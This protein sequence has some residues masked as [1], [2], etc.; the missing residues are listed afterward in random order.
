MKRLV[1]FEEAFLVILSVFM[2]SRLH[3]P[4]WMF[5]VLFFAPD[6]SM[7]GYA[8]GSRVGAFVYNFFHHRAIAVVAY[9]LGALWGYESAQLAGVIMLGHSSFDRV[10]GYGLKY[11]DSF[12]HTHLGWI[13]KS[14]GGGSA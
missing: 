1:L 9:V 2:F 6:L 14:K 7:V 4:W 12:N 3:Y 8:A 5:L 11:P 10:F 13:G